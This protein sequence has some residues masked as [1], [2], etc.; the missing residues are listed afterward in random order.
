MKRK[1]SMKQK[2]VEVAYEKQSLQKKIMHL[3]KGVEE[4]S[5]ILNT[6]K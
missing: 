1:K 3:Q 5:H 4:V 2:L 6:K